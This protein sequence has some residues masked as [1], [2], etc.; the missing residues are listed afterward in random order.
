[1]DDPKHRYRTRGNVQSDDEGA[2]NNGHV[3]GGW[4]MQAGRVSYAEGVQV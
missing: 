3:S 2:D 4:K 1:M